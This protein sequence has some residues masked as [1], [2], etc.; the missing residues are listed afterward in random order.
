MQNPA[1]TSSGF[2][3]DLVY[4]FFAGLFYSI[5]MKLGL[6]ISEHEAIVTRDKW[7]VLAFMLFG[8]VFCIT[9]GIVFCTLAL[10]KTWTPEV[11]AFLFGGIFALLGIFHLVFQLPKQMK[12]MMDDD[13]LRIL[14]ASQNGLTLAAVIGQKPKFYG[15]GDISDVILA[16]ELSIRDFDETTIMWNVIII[17]F[18]PNYFKDKSFIERANA[19]INGFSNNQAYTI[20]N[21]PSAM[22]DEMANALQRYMHS[23][24][25]IK[26]FKK[27]TLD[28]KKDGVIHPQ[29]E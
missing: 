29:P 28:T 24:R 9:I 14:V 19:G 21:Y 15:W 17:I 18:V 13:G 27:A 12:Q 10:Q 22:Q 6:K 4:K 2:F 26:C 23:S 1:Y 25:I 8:D 16:K 7:G 3:Y 5:H 20:V 11:F